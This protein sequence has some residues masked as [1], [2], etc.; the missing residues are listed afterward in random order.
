MRA[1]CFA[2]LR[3]PEGTRIFEIYPLSARSDGAMVATHRLQ[4]SVAKTKRMKQ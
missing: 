2:A 1:F 4:L 3:E